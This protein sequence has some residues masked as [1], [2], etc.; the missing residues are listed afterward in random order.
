MMSAA[1][2]AARVGVAATRALS[3]TEPFAASKAP[4]T[5]EILGSMK[6]RGL[7]GARFAEVAESPASESSA[8]EVLILVPATKEMK[9]SGP[10]LLAGR[11]VSVGET[12]AS[13]ASMF[14]N[15]SRGARGEFAPVEAGVRAAKGL[16]ESVR[17]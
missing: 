2:V 3:S 5:A 10:L 12:S 1:A 16:P 8:V 11:E 14:E 15:R 9:A 6:F 7:G 17:A 4:A 13:E